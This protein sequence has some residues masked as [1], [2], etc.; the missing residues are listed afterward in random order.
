MSQKGFGIVFEY[1]ADG[2]PTWT[3]VGLVEDATPLSI[4]KDTY[5][6]TH[7]GT[8]DGHKTFEGGLVDFGEASI[9]VQYDPD[10]TQHTFLRTRATTAHD[11]PADYRFTFADTGATVET[12]S[13]IVTG[14]EVNTP[15]DDKITAT[16]TFKAS[17]GATQS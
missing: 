16:I 11:S 5:Q 13:A 7:H 15:I 14:F 10:D 9:T 1:D 3:P 2:V 4:T 17:G 12:F 6:T 8:T